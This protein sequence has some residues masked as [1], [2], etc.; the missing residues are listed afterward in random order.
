[1]RRRRFNSGDTLIVSGRKLEM[2]LARF[3][4][5]RGCRGTSLLLGSSAIISLIRF[6]RGTSQ[7]TG[8]V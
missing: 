6:H 5:E 8:P 4:V 3:G 2:G 7:M 1:M